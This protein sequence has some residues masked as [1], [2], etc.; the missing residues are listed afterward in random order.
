MSDD[1]DQIAQDAIAAAL[2]S[3]PRRAAACASLM[4][5]AGQALA[6]LTSHDHAASVHA[7]MSRRHALQA[8]RH[9][10]R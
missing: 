4:R 5:L 9:W 8:A 10:R 7:Q 2:S 3:T 1:A 6:G